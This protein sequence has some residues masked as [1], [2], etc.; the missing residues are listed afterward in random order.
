MTRISASAT[1]R[2]GYPNRGLALAW[3]GQPELDSGGVPAAG[4]LSGM[5]S[6]GTWIFRVEI[7]NIAPVR[8]QVTL[9]WSYRDRISASVITL[10][11]SAATIVDLRV[12][13]PSW[14]STGPLKAWIEGAGEISQDVNVV[15]S[16][17]VMGTR[18]P[19]QDFYGSGGG[20]DGS[21]GGSL[22][23]MS[24]D[25]IKAE[26]P[27]AF[28][29]NR[30]IREVVLVETDRGDKEIKRDGRTL[31]WVNKLTWRNAKTGEQTALVIDDPLW[32]EELMDDRLG[33]N[34]SQDVY[35]TEIVRKTHDIEINGTTIS[36][37]EAIKFATED[38]KT[39]ITLIM[40][41]QGVANS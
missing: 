41:D 9:N 22:S 31:E 2:F 11:P 26:N 40:K 10:L 24:P 30:T 34:W 6:P 4:S 15:L 19:D 37:T 33:A 8:R 38:D 3:S 39:T 7:T 5:P 32:P 28:D 14:G 13:P 35:L 29:E 1:V 27:S 12:E 18:P 20:G 25:D 21:S 17:L 23:D 16:G 36:V